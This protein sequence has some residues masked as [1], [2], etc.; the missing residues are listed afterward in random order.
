M[1]TLYLGDTW[2]KNF[3]N[4]RPSFWLNAHVNLATEALL[5]SQLYTNFQG[6]VVAYKMLKRLTKSVVSWATMKTV[7]T[8]F[9]F[10][11]CM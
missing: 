4:G 10:V 11:A 2:A 1:G 8:A 9:E 7:V 6:Q 5:A 3:E